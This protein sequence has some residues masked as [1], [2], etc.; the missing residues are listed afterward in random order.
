MRNKEDKIMAGIKVPQLRQRSRQLFAAMIP[1][2][3]GKW[4]WAIRLPQ[5][6]MEFQFA[7]RKNYLLRFGLSAS[8]A[9]ENNE[10]SKECRR[11]SD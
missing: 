5:E 4:T 10:R 11:F 8:R 3:G 1:Y 9:C 7:A 6:A 2:D